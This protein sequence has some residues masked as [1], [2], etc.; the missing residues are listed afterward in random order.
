MANNISDY[1]ND[2]MYSNYIYVIEYGGVLM[3][4]PSENLSIHFGSNRHCLQHG[5][6]HNL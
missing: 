5:A 6:R 1:Q 4:S 3:L 2:E